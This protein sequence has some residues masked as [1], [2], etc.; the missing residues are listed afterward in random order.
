MAPLQKALLQ[1][2][3]V[4]LPALV[5]LVALVAVVAL[6]SF[7]SPQNTAKA[8]EGT[9]F[10]KEDGADVRRSTRCATSNFGGRLRRGRGAQP[11][12]TQRAALYAFIAA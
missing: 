10:V 2:D 11:R 5:L 4:A 9:R 1:M 3:D 12:G 7:S 8:A 6:L